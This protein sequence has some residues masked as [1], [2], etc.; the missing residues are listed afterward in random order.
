MTSK[1]KTDVL[2]TVSGSGTIALTNQLSGMT[3]ASLPALG[4]AQMPSGSVL[5]V[6]YGSTGTAITVTTSTETDLGFTASITPNATNNT[7]YLDWFLPDCRKAGNTNL[8]AKLY[9]QVNGGGYVFIEWLCQAFLYTATVNTGSAG[10]AG[11]YKDT[12]YNSTA[13]VD[14]K[15]YIY[16]GQNTG[17]VKV[18]SDTKSDSGIKIQEIKG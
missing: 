16:S 18:N 14:Y 17:E 9:R 4:S 7:L 5:Q 2:E 8:V 15:I 1:L 11:V 3:T 12:S 10:T 6:S 13:Q